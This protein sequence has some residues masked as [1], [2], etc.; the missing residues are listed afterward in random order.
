MEKDG[1]YQ[2]DVTEHLYS[3]QKIKGIEIQGVIVN[4]NDYV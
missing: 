3:K 1:I 4:E 2:F